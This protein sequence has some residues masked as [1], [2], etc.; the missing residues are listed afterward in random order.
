MHECPRKCLFN[1]GANKSVCHCEF[2]Q[3][4]LII[5]LGKIVKPSNEKFR[6]WMDCII[7]IHLF[8]NNP[9]FT[10]GAQNLLSYAMRA[11]T[12]I[13]I[14]T[15]LAHWL[16]YS[17]NGEKQYPEYVTMWWIRKLAAGLCVVKRTH[18]V[19]CADFGPNHKALWWSKARWMAQK[20]C[21]KR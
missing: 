21:F 17:G 11:F 18:Q 1:R 8:I 4:V 10:Q 2:R 14:P 12:A 7:S 16:T 15:S 20:H 13:H 3:R 19:K 9:C 6:K 5:S